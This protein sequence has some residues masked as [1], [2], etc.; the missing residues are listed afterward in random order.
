[1]RELIERLEMLTERRKRDATQRRK[2][3]MKMAKRRKKAPKGADTA[4]P[5]QARLLAHIDG[6]LSGNKS[7]V[8][9]EM[10]FWIEEM[11]FSPSDAFYEDD[12]VH[13]YAMAS[14]IWDADKDLAKKYGYNGREVM[15]T[16]SV[17][18]EPHRD[19]KNIL[20]TLSW[21]IETVDTGD[22]DKYEHDEASS[23]MKLT[24]KVV[25]KMRNVRDI[26]EDGAN[27]NSIRWPG[28]PN[29]SDWAEFEREREKEAY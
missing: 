4:T 11:G 7:E 6:I 26:L 17:E 9:N 28:T 8:Y 15:M 12:G 10:I 2:T 27:F 3:K 14:G 1:M 21:F 16:Y 5:E 22:M 18:F 13:K 24:P 25:K 29:V 19:G 20:S 23:T